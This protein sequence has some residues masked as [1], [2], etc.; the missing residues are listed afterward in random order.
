MLDHLFVTSA[1]NKNWIIGHWLRQLSTRTPGKSLVWYVP[2]SYTKESLASRIILKFPIPKA[3]NYYFSNLVMFQKH[4]QVFPSR[5][6]ENSV[7]LYTHNSLELGT[8]E[9]QVSI[10]LHAR[11]VHFMCSRDQE[12]LI[13]AGLPEQKTKLVLGAVDDNFVQDFSIQKNPKK[14]ILD[15]KFGPRKGAKHLYEV[16]KSLPDY[17]FSVLGRDWDKFEFYSRFAKLQNIEF[18]ESR[19][20]SKSEIYSEGSIFLSLSDLE[21]GPIP[22]L[23]SM[24]FGMWPIVTDTGFAR[25]V[26]DDRRNG[27]LVTFPVS[28]AQIS[29]YVREVPSYFDVPDLVLKLSWDRLLRHYLDSI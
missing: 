8:I 22:L 15:S 28:A 3:Q 16:V 13:F 27:N 24:K 20:V 29:E 4:K 23:E 6:H 5:Y 12:T 11:S 2:T 18:L 7:V 9:T 10:L 17:E 1:A 25:D 26:I 19:S 14:I 21:G